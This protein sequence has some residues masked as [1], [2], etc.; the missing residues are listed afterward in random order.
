MAVLITG[1]ALP[2]TCTF[3]DNPVVTSASAEPRGQALVLR[4]PAEFISF[5]T[6]RLERMHIALIACAHV[7]NVDIIKSRSFGF[8]IGPGV[9]LLSFVANSSS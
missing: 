4:S 7:R 8:T 5:A 9:I 3:S 2:G 1:P 6:E